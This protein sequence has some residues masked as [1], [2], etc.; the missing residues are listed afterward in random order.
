MSFELNNTDEVPKD[1][2]IMVEIEKTVNGKS[3][4]LL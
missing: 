4:L 3:H 2:L 1:A